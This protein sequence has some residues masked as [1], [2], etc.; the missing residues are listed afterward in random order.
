MNQSSRWSRLHLFLTG[1]L[2]LLVVGSSA[3][4]LANQWVQ[5]DLP[6]I[7]TNELLH[8]LSQSWKVF[9][10]SYWP[11][12]FPRELYRPLTSLMLAGEW[13]I[14][15]GSP[16]VFR[17]TSILIY[18][19]VTLAC[20]GLARRLMPAWA[21]FAV[22]ALF[23][24]HPVHVEAVAV[25]VNQAELMVAL[26]L[27]AMTTAWIDHRRAGL[28]VISGWGARMLLLWFLA[29]LFKEHAAVLP[30]L[31]ILAEFT[32]LNDGSTR[33]L[34]RGEWR[35]LGLSVA[36][37]VAIII[38][39]R[40]LVLHGNTKG[41]FTAEALVDQG[42]GGRLL[43]MLGV[44]PEWF[45]LLI[46]PEHLRADYSPQVIVPAESFGAPQLIGV[47]LLAIALFLMIRSWRREPVVA[48]GIGWLG[49]SLGPV[50]NVLVP[51]GIVMAER[52]LFLGSAGF[53]IGGVALVWVIGKQLETG[54]RPVIAIAGTAFVAL[55]LMGLTRSAS[56]QKVWHDLPTLWHQTLI[57][58]PLSYRA[59]HAYAQVLYKAGQLGSAERHYRRAMELYPGAWPLYL[60]LADKY[61]LAGN[62]WP[63]I[64]LY[65]HLLRLNPAHTAGRGSL[66]ACLVHVGEYQEAAD[67][68]RIGIEFGRQDDD[69]RRYLL[70]AD[71]ARDAAAP[72]GTVRLPPPQ[73]IDTITR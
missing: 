54:R 10:T 58:A 30:A 20:W 35:R 63:A 2:I 8:S 34:E 13:A 49:I 11:D 4:G 62:C 6:I 73:A 48:F 55:L 70:V 19:L 71:S 51:T 23:A 44:V 56:R 68:A 31:L 29:I 32:V 27:M 1:T 65:R 15:G 43:T 9:T 64:E 21:A 39:I 57:D 45:R 69:F 14:G 37:L 67:V 28:P 52:T 3:T 38:G 16:L 41:S 53:L 72:A 12:P 18:T 24:V 59:H 33:R 36:L 22:A 50:H 66:I 47:T 17:I 25:A 46:W 40:D 5:D 60:D 26:L 61:R 42:V 7:A